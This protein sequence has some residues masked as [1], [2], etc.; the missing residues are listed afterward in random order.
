MILTLTNLTLGLGLPQPGGSVRSQGA[1][2]PSR[3]QGVPAVVR[4]KTQVSFFLLSPRIPP[5]SLRQLL[6]SRPERSFGSAFFASIQFSDVANVTYPQL[7][8]R[9]LDGIDVLNFDVGL[10]VSAGCVVD[11]DFHDNFLASTMGPIIVMV[12]LGA[13]YLAA[14]CRNRGSDDAIARVNRKHVS[15]VLLVT[16]LVYSSVSSTVFRMFVCDEL[17]DGNAYLRADYSIDCRSTKHRA[18][19]VFAGI[20][21]LLYPV[22]IPLFYTVLLH[23]TREVLQDESSRQANPQAKTIAALWESYTPKRYY[24]E[25]IECGR[26]MLLTGV[27]VFIFPNSAAQIAV[28]LLMAFAFL[29]LSEV[30]APFASAWDCWVARSGHILVFLTMYVALLLKVDVSDERED[31]QRL[32][33]VVLVVMNLVLFLAAVAEMIWMWRATKLE[34]N[35][36]P[37]SRSA[38]GVKGFGDFSLKARSNFPPV[39][40]GCDESPVH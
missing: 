37:R 29:V 31:S 26:R 35:A 9:F 16:F 15:A 20:M 38:G 34:E 7:Y 2:V 11:F 32:F 36:M 14:S 27:V 22:G 25:V 19:K 10:A 1:L 12:I 18:L 6:F 40:Q 23:R 13:T 3:P 24:H 39:D 30:L 4:Q 21:V 8:Q 33:A 5:F 28:S 17:D